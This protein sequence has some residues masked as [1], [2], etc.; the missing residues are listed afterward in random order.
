MCESPKSE[1]RHPPNENAPTG[2][3]IGTFTPTMPTSMSNSNWRAVPPSRVNTAVPLAKGLELISS[4]ASS[5]VFT[6]TTESTGPKISSSYTFMP[7]AT[8]STSETPTKKP[9]PSNCCVVPSTTTSA[10]SAAAPVT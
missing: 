2:T 4:T 7:G 1:L 10:P 8:R 3:G 5:Y 6:R 9:S